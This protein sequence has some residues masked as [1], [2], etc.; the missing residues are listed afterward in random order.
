MRKK[1]VAGNWKMN[2]LLSDAIRFTEEL[3]NCISS[4]ERLATE[5]L[6]FPGFT[7]ID[8]VRNNAKAFRIG[9]Q[10]FYPEQ[11]GAFTGEVSIEQLK[12]LNMK[13]VLVGH[14]ERRILFNESDA[15][16]RKKLI[17]AIENHISPILC[18]GETHE[19]RNK[20]VHFNF[21]SAQL[22]NALTDF[23]E[24]QLAHV[25]L[26]YEPVWAI[27]TGLTATTQQA[28]EMHS[29]IRSWFAGN[30]SKQLAENLSILYG[31]SCNES[32]AKELF[33]CANV[34]G[35]L[36]GGASLDAKQFISIV[37]IMDG[38]F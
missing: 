15:F 18:I 17:S 28:E 36:I 31:G 21:I 6:I 32:N 25:I 5:V 35:G 33:S 11:S 37:N 23:T 19:I 16:I 9:A 34:D 1:I 30:F 26:A 27:G 4:K 24:E 22:S 38:L 29:H 20:G 7:L 8:A 10:N 13:F 3:D 14:S 2:L 12:D